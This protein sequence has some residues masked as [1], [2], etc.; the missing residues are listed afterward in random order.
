MTRKASDDS[1]SADVARKEGLCARIDRLTL[2]GQSTTDRSAELTL[3]AVLFGLP[4]DDHVRQALTTQSNF[5]LQQATLDPTKY[6]IP[7]SGSNPTFG[8]FYHGRIGAGLQITLAST[9][10][11]NV[12][13]LRML[14]GRLGE[15][16]APKNWFVFVTREGSVFKC[17]KPFAMQMGKFALF[18][19]ELKLP[20]RKHHFPSLTGVS[21]GDVD[22]AE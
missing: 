16:L 21:V 11:L 7:F 6:F 10:K 5:T 14:Y 17:K 1:Y 12:E 9:H 18:A 22:F 3:F 20:S 4:Y 15:G 8:S 2:A 19:L 13:G